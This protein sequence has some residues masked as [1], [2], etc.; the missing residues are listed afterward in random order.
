MNVVLAGTAMCLARS[1]AEL[2][3]CWMWGMLFVAVAEGKL[4]MVGHDDFGL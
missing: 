1:L 4:W 3:G 2:S